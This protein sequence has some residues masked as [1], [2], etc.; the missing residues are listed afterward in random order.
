MIVA[1]NMG[2]T[3]PRRLNK[4]YDNYAE[5]CFGIKENR[6]KKTL[7]IFKGDILKKTL[8]DYLKITKS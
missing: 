2:F 7:E 3:K 6:N 5:Y 8:T 1:E 4:S